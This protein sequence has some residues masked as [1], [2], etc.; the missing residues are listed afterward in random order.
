MTDCRDG[1]VEEL[2]MTDVVPP[3]GDR[4]LDDEPWLSA[5]RPDSA[6]ASRDLPVVPQTVPAGV[7]TPADWRSMNDESVPD[8]YRTPGGPAV[9]QRTPT[10]RWGVLSCVLG[11]AG[12][13]QLA[14]LYLP[15]LSLLALAFGLVG[16]RQALIDPDSVRTKGTALAGIAL[17][18][19]G[20]IAGILLYAH[21]RTFTSIVDL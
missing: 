18:A 16:R 9:L 11:V 3:G 6:T 14:I 17:G 19:L 12:F 13:G 4:P 20:I 7:E 15:V 8:G 10:D 21:Y 2:F 5:N 1:S